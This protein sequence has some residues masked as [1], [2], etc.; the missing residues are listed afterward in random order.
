MIFTWARQ[1][2][3]AGV[4]SM[5][6]RNAEYIMRCNPR[7]AFPLVDNKLQTKEVA[8]RF[9]VPTTAVFLVVKN[10]GDIPK[11]EAVLGDQREFVIKPARGSGGSGI[12]LIVDRGKQG[13]IT[14]SGETLSREDFTYH[15]A[16]ILSGIYS[17]GSH[18]DMVILEALIHPAPVFEEVTY[19][20]VP[21]VRIITYRGVPVMA[22]VRLPTRASDGKA[23]LHRGAIGAGI[24]LAT[25]KT[26]AAVHRSNVVST[27]PD[28]G[29]PVS[30]ISVP[31]WEQMLLMAA[32]SMDM[33][34]LGFLGMDLAI[35]RD[36]GPLLLEL[37]ARPG[38]AIQ[39]ANQSGLRARLEKVDKAPPEVFATPASRVEWAR[40]AFK[41]N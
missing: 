1:L 14:Q 27:H 12:V 15:L 28:T 6:R 30:G 40:N 29:K 10:H 11:T 41:A 33:T 16:D 21:D 22:M 5:N 26:T 34:G 9:A 24:D 38:L 2:R 25:G 36:H 37:N 23:N 32:V 7:S 13:F 35:D 20:G 39:I 4:L 31:H 19:Q 17:L 3:E 18:E 8:A